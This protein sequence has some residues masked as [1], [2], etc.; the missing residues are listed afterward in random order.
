MAKVIM[1]RGEGGPDFK[2]M[3]KYPSRSLSSDAST[4]FTDELGKNESEQEN[5]TELTSNKVIVRGISISSNQALRFR[6]EFYSKNSF[7]DSDLDVDTFI[8]AVDL[9]LAAHGRLI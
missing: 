3:G 7:T 6:L 8:G 4:H 2:I 1:S 5:L 9:D